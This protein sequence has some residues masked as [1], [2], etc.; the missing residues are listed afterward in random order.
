MI[1]KFPDLAP[2]V[3]SAVAAFQVDTNSPVIAEFRKSLAACAEHPEQVLGCST[4]FK[5]LFFA[6]YE[7]CMDH[8]LYSLA[9]E[10]VEAKR[11]ASTRLPEIAFDERD[12]VRL[13]FAYLRL[14]SWREALSVLENPGDV[15]IV[16]QTD[17]PWG[18]AF[19]PFVPA[20]RAALCREKL[21]LPP[22][23]RAGRFTMEKPCL[24]LHTPSTFA[25]SPDGL[26]VAIGAELLQLGFDLHTNKVAR[27]P[28]SGYS[29]ITSL[30]LG[31]GRF[32]IGTAGEGLVEY[33]KSR[34]EC[35]LMTE[36]DGLLLNSISSL[37]LQN[38]TLWIGFGRQQ[39]GGLGSL[40]LRTGRLSAFTP[41]LPLDPLSSR[42]SESQN[43]P[44]R[45]AVT[46]LT[47]GLP[48]ELWML[49]A[50]RGLCRYRISS[51]A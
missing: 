47:V 16:M 45:H 14:Q 38:K 12:K 27:L 7:W 31:S 26:W 21:G 37:C 50:G 34:G 24:C 25:A 32:W 28:I 3:L 15:S 6:P 41:P 5:Y 13:A 33:D 10:L 17:G 20:Q 23:V 1:Q 30:C 42:E 51:N 19:T 39:A 49:V 18:A 36:K 35:R 46:G 44:P 4:Y 2:H 40:D 8:K 22:L 29:G 9:V 11:H 43:E 48:D